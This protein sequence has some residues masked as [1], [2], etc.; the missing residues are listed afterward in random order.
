[1][2]YNHN[3]T[4]IMYNDLYYC[5]EDVYDYVIDQLKRAYLDKYC[6]EIFDFETLENRYELVKQ[7]FMD[8]LYYSVF[9]GEPISN[10]EIYYDIMTEYSIQIY[11]CDEKMVFQSMI[12]SVDKYETGDILVHLYDEVYGYGSYLVPDSKKGTV[13][14]L[15][16]VVED[17]ENAGFVL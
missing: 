5:R 3:R 17:A 15:F 4:I 10:E 11:A 7:R 16:S 14:E 2:H 1:M 13:E 9:E 6:V 12:M 8:A